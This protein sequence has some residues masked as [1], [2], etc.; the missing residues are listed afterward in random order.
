[1]LSVLLSNV[2]IFSPR[3]W[4]HDTYCQDNATAPLVILVPPSYLLANRMPQEKEPPV[5][6]EFLRANTKVKHG[7]VELV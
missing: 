1:M 6:K 2:S 5:L 7:D 4:L 3:Y